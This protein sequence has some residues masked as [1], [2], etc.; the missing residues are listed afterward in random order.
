MDLNVEQ[1]GSENRPTIVFLHGLGVS[2]WMWHDQVTQLEQDYHCVVVD[3][4]GNGE[5]YLRPWHSFAETAAQVADLIRREAHGGQAHVVGLS[6]GGYVTL[7]LLTAHP[8]VVLS[9]WSVG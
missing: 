5:S 3:L 9:A 1:Y 8:E 4:P 7:H 2:G 6:L